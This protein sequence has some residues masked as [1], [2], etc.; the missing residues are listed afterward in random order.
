MKNLKV[1]QEFMFFSPSNTRMQFIKIVLF[2]SGDTKKHDL[3]MYNGAKT[4]T[5]IH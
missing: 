5:V 2:F 1:T 3:M 4:Y